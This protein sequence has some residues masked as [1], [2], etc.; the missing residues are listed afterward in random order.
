MTTPDAPPALATFDDGAV[1]RVLCVVAHPDDMEYGGSALVAR[2][3]ERGAE[4]AYLLLTGGEAGIE[5]MD[6]DETRRVRA[7]E[8]QRACEQVGVGDLEI[9]DH[10]DGTLVYGLDLRHDVA[11]AVRR[12]RPDTVVVMTWE[13]E[14]PWGLNQADHRAAGVAAIDG[15]RDADNTWIFRDLADAGLPKWGPDRIV[16]MGHPAPT[17]GADVSGEPL[18]RAIRSLEAHEQYLAA[19]PWH[20]APRDMLGGM[21][22]AQGAALGVPN[23]VLFKVYELKAP[24]TTDDAS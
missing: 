8:Q 18:E 6:P 1:R 2:W 13:L 12:F 10:P 16:V 14:T 3:V 9:L 19:L 17:H 11:R 4:A 23:A 5:G 24:P 20:P 7:V 15:V 22:A 21:T